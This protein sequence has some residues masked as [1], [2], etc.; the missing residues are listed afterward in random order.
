MLETSYFTNKNREARNSIHPT[1][2]GTNH[3]SHRKYEAGKVDS[4]YIKKLGASSSNK[5]SEAR[6]QNYANKGTNY[7]RTNSTSQNGFRKK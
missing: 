7:Q 2:R 5:E 1:D 3:N 6:S 4:S